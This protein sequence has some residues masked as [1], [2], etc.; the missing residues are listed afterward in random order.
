MTITNSGP[1]PDPKL[2][3]STDTQEKPGVSPSHETIA[4]VGHS[5]RPFSRIWS[6]L[7]CFL[8]G[9]LLS[10]AFTL[11][12]THYDDAK[13]LLIIQFTG[14]TENLKQDVGAI[15]PILIFGAFGGLLYSLRERKMELPYI[16]QSAFSP[17]KEKTAPNQSTVSTGESFKGEIINL[18][19][20]ADCLAGI[21]GALGIFLILPIDEIK[22]ISLLKLL[23]TAMIGG[24]GGRS[25]LD[26]ALDNILQKQEELAKEQKK[27]EEHLK[28]QEEQSKKDS[29]TIRQLSRY[30]DSSLTLSPKEEQD[31]LENIKMTSREVR[32]GTIF[33]NA[34]SA[35]Y[36]NSSKKDNPLAKE[37]VKNA[38]KVFESLRDSDE[39]KDNDRYPAHVGYA[40]MALG[41]WK[42]AIEQL[43]IAKATLNNS[44]RGEK[45]RDD[46]VYES[47]RVICKVNL[48]KDN[49]TGNLELLK[50]LHDGLN[51]FQLAE[52][53][54]WDRVDGLLS[55]EKGNS[56]IHKWLNENRDNLEVQQWL[57]ASGN[58]L[59]SGGDS[60]GTQRLSEAGNLP[61]EG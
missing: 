42:E 38:L 56:D 47:N 14:F 52:E 13:W 27:T 2:P 16:S 58:K 31:L 6:Y 22:N 20:V 4:K 33:K 41:E 45:K 10:F 12:L 24:Y 37:V 60:S 11:Y 19:I 35:L 51:A 30:L 49:V 44:Q 5:Q 39:N 46:W 23:A 55:R 15:I 17:T 59:D 53:T 7:F 3:P 54:I 1:K 8:L 61:G 50:S 43:D 28:N 34:Q 57:K 48:D 9:I 26:R 40:H 18:G 32:F 29:E 25:L 21:G 36:E